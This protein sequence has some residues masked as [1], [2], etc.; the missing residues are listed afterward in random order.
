MAI[1]PREV[2]LPPAQGHTLRRGHT[3]YNAA[4]ALFR[5]FTWYR[6]VVSSTSTTTI[7]WHVNAPRASVYRALL[8]PRAIARWRVPTGM[9]SQV[10][11]FDAR[12]GGTFRVS[13]TYDAPTAAGKTT[14]HTDTYH[15]RFAKLVPN[16]QV[17][18]VIE[19]ETDDPALRG[20][21]TITTT[22]ADAAGPDGPG[23]GTEIHAVHEGLPPGVAPADNETGWRDSLAKLAALVE[24]SEKGAA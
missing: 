20:E 22:L 15:G 10:H 17:V 11:A 19:F 24:A 14:A 1:V 6:P 9:T 23:S 21:M 16:V 13:L 3:L 5:R 12:E 7:R 2:A 18:E 4:L 8:D